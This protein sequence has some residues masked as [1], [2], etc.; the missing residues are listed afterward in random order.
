[1]YLPQKQY[2]DIIASSL[3]QYCILITSVGPLYSVTSIYCYISEI[4]C[5]HI[6]HFSTIK[7]Q[8][9]N[10][11]IIL[12]LS[13]AV[14]AKGNKTK[15]VTDKSLCNEMASL[16][17]LV[18]LAANE[19]KLADKA[20]NNAT[21]T[22]EIQSKASDAS[23]QLTTMQANTTLVSTC[24]VISA[25]QDTEDS[26]SEMKSLQ[27]SVDLAANQTALESKAKGNAAEIAALQSKAS[28]AAT[29]LTIMT[30]NTT[31]VSACSAIAVTKA[32]E[33][34]T[35]GMLKHSNNER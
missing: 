6:L 9:S 20:K 8:F 23:T 1:V 10:L 13:I 3:H 30:S 15:A 28:A 27:K 7:M 22:A 24:A 34:A 32:E 26:C 31:L 35:K 17:K 33:K 16:T 25:A 4:S 14:A 2:L 19:T 18:N 12:L 5:L 21:K 29:K 11:F